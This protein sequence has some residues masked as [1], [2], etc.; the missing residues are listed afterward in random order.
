MSRHD[1]D[2]YVSMKDV[3]AAP[4]WVSTGRCC[5]SSKRSAALNLNYECKGAYTKN[6][7]LG[8]DVYEMLCDAMKPWIGWCGVCAASLWSASGR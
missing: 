6:M 8:D 1:D 7:Y 2:V 5:S 4:G 3:A